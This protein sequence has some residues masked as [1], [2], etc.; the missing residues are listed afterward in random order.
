[1]NSMLERLSDTQEAICHI[2][3]LSRSIGGRGSCTPQERQAS[4]YVVTQMNGMGIENACVEP[5]RAIPST[6]WPYA[7]AFTAA[8]TGSALVLSLGGRDVL[9]LAM[10]LNLLGVWGMLAETEFA[11]N[12]THW[13]LPHST[14][15]NVSGSIAPAGPTR[16]R[17][18]L[19]A[20]VD[21]H[22]TPIFYSSNTWYKL[23]ATLVSLSF[24]CMIAGAICFGLAIWLPGDWIYLPALLILLIQGAGA[25]LCIQA[26][27]TPY[28]PGANDNASGVGVALALAQ[29]LTNEPLQQTGVHLAITGCEEVGDWGIQAYL[30]KWASRLGEETLYIILDE[31]GLGTTKYLSR[32]G[33]LIKH[34]THP[35]ALGIARQ[36]RQENQALR[37]ME[38]PGL[39]YTDALPITKRGLM[40]LT[41][42]AVPEEGS[43]TNSYWHQMSDTLEHIN[44]DDLENS[45][46]VTWQILKVFDQ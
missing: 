21:T 45:L 39:A 10:L 29:R 37:L 4:E 13:V 3:Y 15:Q 18:V 5:F 9:I 46:Q 34:P 7:L 1:L 24:L 33:L 40:A 11:P 14:S 6:Y 28:T 32:D 27:F 26:D 44:P 42:C 43:E 16:R 20:H 12:W 2:R 38:G 17:V 31:I 19:C 25:A 23:F 8:C 35:R 22:R 36:V 41:V 30:D